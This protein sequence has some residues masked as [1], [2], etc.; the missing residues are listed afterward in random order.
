VENPPAFSWRRVDCVWLL[1]IRTTFL[2]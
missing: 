2:C 1:H